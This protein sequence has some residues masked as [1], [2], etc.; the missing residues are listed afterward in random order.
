MN[1]MEAAG[2]N[3]DHWLVIKNLPGELH[4]VHRETGTERQIPA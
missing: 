3:P 2:L 1:L 4:I